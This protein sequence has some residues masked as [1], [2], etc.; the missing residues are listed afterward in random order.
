MRPEKVL[1]CRKRA[2]TFIHCRFS[3]RN[4]KIGDRR[5]STHVGGGVS[6]QSVPSEVC[7][8]TTWP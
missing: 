1:C 7:L 5:S 8:G 2:L 4:Y 6:A 3:F